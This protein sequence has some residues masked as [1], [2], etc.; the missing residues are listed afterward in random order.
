MTILHKKLFLIFIVAAAVVLFLKFTD[1]GYTFSLAGIQEIAT[2]LKKQANSHYLPGVLVFIGVYVFVNFWFPAAAVLTLLAG[3]IYGTLLGTVY[4]DL[5]ATLGALLAFWISRN[6][7][8][9]WIQ[10]KWHRQLIGF[11]RELAGRGY[12]YLLLVRLIPV[13]PYVL[14]N[15]LAGLT[16][17]HFITFVWTTALGSVPGILILSYAGRQL[18]NI[19]SVSQVFTFKV[20]I[21]FILLAGFVG[22][23]T[24]IKIIKDKKT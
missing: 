13:M 20:I 8:G 4:V 23:V 19:T 3:F 2:D 1:F 16:R 9:R 18:L 5:A 7:A 17:V 12:I 24:F 22:S 21:A 11:N 6:F 14:I 15:Y 10:Q